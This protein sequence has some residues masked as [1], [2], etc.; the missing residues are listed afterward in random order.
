MATVIKKRKKKTWNRGRKK[1]TDPKVQVAFYVTQSVVDKHG[2]MD[3][4]RELCIKIL[5]TTS[6]HDY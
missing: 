3:A 6:P 2:G 4:S 1:S 5:E